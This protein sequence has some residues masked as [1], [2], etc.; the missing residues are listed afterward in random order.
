[1]V[2]FF[3]NLTKSITF[4]LKQENADKIKIIFFT[5]LLNILKYSYYLAFITFLGKFSTKFEV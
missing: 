2:L 3:F 5:S 1:M 4:I